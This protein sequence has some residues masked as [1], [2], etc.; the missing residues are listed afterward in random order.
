[1]NELT[2]HPNVYATGRSKGL[3]SMLERAWVREHTPGDGTIYVISGFAN[4]NGGV[5][6]F[7]VFR[8]HITKGGQLVAIFSGSTH[9]RLTSKQVVKEMLNCGA[10]VHIINRKRLLH[11][12]CYGV[13]SSKGDALVVTSGNFTG[14]GMS[15]NVELSV[16][17]EP[18]STLEM[19]FVWDDLLKNILGQSWNFHNPLL[20][21]LNNP[22]WKLLYDE[23]AANIILDESEE[24]TMVLALSH[25]DTA[26]I[27][28]KPGSNASKGTQYF[29]LSKD[30]YDFFPPLIIRNARG[31]KAT[32]SCL[33]RMHY[34]DLGIIDE[35]CR[36]TFEAENNLDFRLGTGKLRYTGLAAAGDIAT[37]S[38]VG[39]MDYELR[40]YRKNTPQYPLLN[41]YAINFIGHQG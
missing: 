8:N 22:A 41:N 33:I 39:E 11:A 9:A 32:Y 37:I 3:I 30:C 10:H 21:D 28:A 14:P 38:R 16:F 34:V 18:S 36:V 7:D 2:L 5:R 13:K 1:M 20:D 26:R 25:A 27:N 29:W 40:I 17:L 35:S 23:Q 19:G 12:K 15:Q 4:Y 24:V 6:F 31:H